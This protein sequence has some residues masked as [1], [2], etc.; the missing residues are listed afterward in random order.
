MIKMI[1]MRKAERRKAKLR[2]ALAGPAGSGKTLTS[3]LIAYGLCPDWDRICMVDTEKGKGEMYAGTT[4]DGMVIGNYN[5][6]QLTPPYEPEKYM[7]AIKLAEKSDQE[8]IILDSISHAWAGEGG[9]LERHDMLTQAMKNPNAYIAWNKVTPV[10]YRFIDAMNNTKCHMIATMRTKVAYIQ[11]KDK[12]GNTVIKKVGTEPI[13]REGMDYE[14]IIYFELSRDHLVT[15]QRDNTQLFEGKTFIP[16]V[17]TGKAMLAWLETGVQP[18]LQTPVQ[19]QTEISPRMQSGSKKDSVGNK[20]N[21]PGEDLPREINWEEIP[22]TDEPLPESLPFKEPKEQRPANGQ[23]ATQAQVKKILATAKEVGLSEDELEA[24]CE[25]EAGKSSRNLTKAEA[26]RLIDVLLGMA[27]NRA[28][29]PP[30]I[31]AGG[32]N[33]NGNGARRRLF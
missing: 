18:E 5:Y 20:Q 16:T 17:E 7:E 33:G 22:F 2:L 10:H 19:S 31:P 30:P 21:F 24:L 29:A 1:Q 32:G 23:A 25:N 27:K 12:D 28:P 14:F 11:Q 15:V 9:L 6:I 26:S 8:V 3:L 4:W 13:Q